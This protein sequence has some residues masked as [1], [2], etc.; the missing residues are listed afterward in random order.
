MAVFGPR[1]LAWLAGKASPTA[2]GPVLERVNAMKVHVEVDMTPEEARALMGLP[3]VA[4]HAEKDDGRDAGADESRLRY[5]RSRG[6]DAGLDA[7]LGGGAKA[8]EQFQKYLWDSAR[9]WSA[10]KK[11]KP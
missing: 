3:D 11:D 4:P 7:V 8:F 9:P 10:G 2:K 5:R 1:F 6:H